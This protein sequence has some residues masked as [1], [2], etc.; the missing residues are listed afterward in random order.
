MIGWFDMATL[1]LPRRR[2][3]LPWAGSLLPPM[4]CTPGAAACSRSD[5]VAWRSGTS[6]RLIWAM[7]L[8]IS[9]RRAAPAA[10]VTTISSSPSASV[11]MAKSIVAVPSAST[12]TD[13]VRV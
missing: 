12:S 11:V 8:P 13:S 10:P 4:T 2:I 9:R 7:A 3:C 5:T 6:V 1:E